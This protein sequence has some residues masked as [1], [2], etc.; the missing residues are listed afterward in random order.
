[1]QY[2]ED[3]NAVPL[4]KAMSG[5]SQAEYATAR[6]STPPERNCQCIDGRGS[7][8]RNSAVN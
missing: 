1:M 8:I 5:T 6:G 2:N 4:P 7:E 3:L